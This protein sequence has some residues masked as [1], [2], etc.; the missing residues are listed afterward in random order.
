MDIIIFIS[1]IIVETIKLF[2][3][4][5]NTDL[6]IFG[7]KEI[8]IQSGFNKYVMMNAHYAKAMNV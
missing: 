5:I 8:Q 6:S 3:I 1:K 4:K 7:I 2:Y